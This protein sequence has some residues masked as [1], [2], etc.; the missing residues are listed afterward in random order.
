MLIYA[1]L[2]VLGII[3]GASHSKMGR[4]FL[5]QNK[6][7]IFSGIAGCYALG[8]FYISYLQYSAWHL[9]ELTRLFLPP[10]QK[11]SYFFFYVGTRFWAPYVI[12]FVVAILFL[13]A[14]HWAN[15]KYHE[16]FFEREEIY[17]AA[18]CIFVVG[19]PGVLLYIPLVL[20]AYICAQLF[21]AL[22]SE[23]LS[24]IPMYHLWVPLAMSVIIGMKWIVSVPVWSLWKI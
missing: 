8:L 18:T 20:V 11:W 5:V 10:H 16:R 4:S 3:L 7:K 19:Y 21:S 9:G 23:G 6:K 2:L 15:R 13:A 24:R 22:R 1:S 17:L 14:A 12:S